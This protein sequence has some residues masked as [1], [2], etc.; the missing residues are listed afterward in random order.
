ME[1]SYY[2]G[3]SLQS[4]AKEYKLSTELICKQLGIELIEIDDWNCCGALEVS[5]LNSTL[6]LSLVAR[7]LKI[8]SLQSAKLAVSC[9]ACLNNLLS[10]QH[11]LSTNKELR[12]KINKIL[13]C[14]FREIEIKH[15]L[16]LLWTNVGLEKI[17]ENA[18]KDLKGL[19]TVSYYGCL[20]VRPSNIMKSDDPDNPIRLDRI[21]SILGGE[22]LEFTNKTKCCGGGILMTYR[23]KAMKMGEQILTEA[24]ERGAACIL[25]ACPLCQLALETVS[26]KVNAGRDGHKI[27]ILYFTQLIGL[28][29]GIEPNKL[30]LNRNLVSPEAVIK[31]I[32]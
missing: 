8:T 15:I 3:C 13:N 24:G 28:A 30:G 23:D 12:Q 2:P 18:K 29:F 31:F 22:P 1:I 6:A 9:N 21:V 26:Q 20:S 27:P 4:S 5:S 16:D 14:E 25:T 10:V 19:K 17:E 32:G 11:K 7:N